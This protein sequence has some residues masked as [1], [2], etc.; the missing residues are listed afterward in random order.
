MSGLVL[1]TRPIDEAESTAAELRENGY[2]SMFAPM[3]AIQPIR[4]EESDFSA[5]DGVLATSPRAIFLLA[6]AVSE[7]KIPVYAVGDYTAAAAQEAGFINVH[8]AQGAGGDL[9]AML[10]TTPKPLKF[11]HVRGQDVAFDLAGALEKS[12]HSVESIV[13]YEALKTSRFESEVRDAL[14]SGRIKA[15]T[16]FSKRTAETFLELVHKEKL[17]AALRPIKALCISQS[18]LECV[19]PAQWLGVYVS[20]SPDRAGMLNLLRE[21]FRQ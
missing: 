3:L 5:Y 16:F 15:V 13:V 11:L 20:A 10:A 2:E 6:E 12:G 1:I 9:A 21:E 8:N 7:R 18:V 17:E 4:F 14:V 19:R